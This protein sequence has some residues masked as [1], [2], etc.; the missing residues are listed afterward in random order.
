MI[1]FRWSFFVV[2][3][4]KPSARLK[5]IWYPNT[6]FVPVPVRSPF[7]VPCS[8]TW[9]S[10]SRYCFIVSFV[11]IFLL[12]KLLSPGWLDKHIRICRSP[13]IWLR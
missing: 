4:G 5:R 12:H 10:R 9:R 8:F 11:F 2:S 7:I 3:S 1:D 13:R 6:L